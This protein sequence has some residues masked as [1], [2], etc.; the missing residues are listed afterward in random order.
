[1]AAKLYT[2]LE[3]ASLFPKAAAAA[4]ENPAPVRGP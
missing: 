3:L 2:V 1:M 4:Q